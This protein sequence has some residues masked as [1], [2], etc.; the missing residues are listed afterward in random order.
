MK[1][2]QERLSGKGLKRR[3]LLLLGIAHQTQHRE[4]TSICRR[5]NGIVP[6]PQL[7]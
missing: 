6:L 3:Q 5:L 2:P 1:H 7:S 4:R